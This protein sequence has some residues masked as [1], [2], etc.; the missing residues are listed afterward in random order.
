MSLVIIA[1]NA[2]RALIV[3]RDNI[4]RVPGWGWET[5][6]RNR[7]RDRTGYR[8]GHLDAQYWELL[9]Q[10]LVAERERPVSQ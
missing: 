2:D 6:G 3:V 10:A 5:D 9:V 1:E 7:A 8:E 4:L